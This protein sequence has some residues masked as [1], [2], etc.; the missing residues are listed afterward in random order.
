MSKS[1]VLTTQLDEMPENL[2]MLKRRLSVALEPFPQTSQT[3]E[4]YLTESFD[5]FDSVDGLME[6]FYGRA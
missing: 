5:Q 3:L 2:C 1:F 6:L 4:A